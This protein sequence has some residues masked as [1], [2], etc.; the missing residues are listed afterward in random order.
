MA[1]AEPD[2]LGQIQAAKER[3]FRSTYQSHF[4]SPAS[5]PNLRFGAVSLL[6]PRGSGMQGDMMTQM[7]PQ[8]QGGMDMNQG[9]VQILQLN[10]SPFTDSQMQWLQRNVPMNAQFRGGQSPRMQGQSPNPQFSKPGS[11]DGNR[12]PFKGGST[13]PRSMQRG[14]G[15]LSNA[16]GIVVRNSNSRLSMKGNA[17]L[18]IIRLDNDYPQAPGDINCPQSFTYD[19]FYR[20]VPG[21]TFE[22]C[23]SGKLSPNVQKQFLEAIDLMEMK[24]VSGITGDCGFMMYF[25]KLARTHTRKPVFVSALAQLPAITCSFAKND[26]IAVLTANGE[27]L[28][29]MHDLIKD[30]CGVDPEDP[31]FLFVGCEDVPG[32]ERVALGQKVDVASVTPGIVRKAQ[33]VLQ[34]CPAVRAFLMES[35]ELTPYSDALRTATGLPVYDAIT[36]C[37]YFISGFRDNRRVGANDW[38]MALDGE[39]TNYNVIAD[40]A[41]RNED[42]SA[43]TRRIS[44]TEPSKSARRPSSTSPACP[45]DA[46]AM[47]AIGL[48]VK[49]RFKSMRKAFRKMDQNHDGRI[50]KEE[51]L[52]MCRQWNIPQSE[53]LMRAADVDHTGTLDFAEFAAK[54]A[55]TSV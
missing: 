54:I 24:G 25:Q 7:S 23:Q 44:K 11:R 32:L 4:V 43:M 15:G 45:E 26:L 3:R 37:D 33:S 8:M 21:L 41:G 51:L 31:R 14:G 20:V 5:R 1:M 46:A 6:T 50:S 53:A 34:A 52:E 48:E 29:P 47:T 19:V 30:E 22:M 55:A 13:T 38:Q 16:G 35:T 36:C 39:Q 28:K 49:E 27:S 2:E 12:V 18:G 40:G 17:T 42:A 9:S 10:N